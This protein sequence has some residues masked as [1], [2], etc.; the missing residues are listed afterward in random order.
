M[1]GVGFSQAI[2]RATADGDRATLSVLIERL[3]QHKGNSWASRGRSVGC[4]RRRGCF[5]TTSRKAIL[6]LDKLGSRSNSRATRKV[7]RKTPLARIDDFRFANG[8]CLPYSFIAYT[9]PFR[10][11]D[12]SRGIL[13]S[14][15]L[16]AASSSLLRL[17]SSSLAK[18]YSSRENI[19]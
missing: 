3:E 1:N 8:P 18:R 17:S 16:L 5:A 19:K 4:S 14:S 11:N 2:G 6:Y 13:R 7:Y 15:S 9:L 10:R 12:R